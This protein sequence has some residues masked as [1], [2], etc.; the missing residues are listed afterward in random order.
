[1]TLVR[2]WKTRIDGIRQRY[3][4]KVEEDEDDDAKT[5]I[6]EWIFH[7]EYR[8]GS[9]SG[10]RHWEVR[11]QV[12]N[13]VT[14]GEAIGYAEDILGSYVDEELITASNFETDKAG[15]DFIKYG[16]SLDARYK[17]V[18]TVRPQYNYPKNRWGKWRMKRI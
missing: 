12:P 8:D 5:H 6:V 10:I 7:W 9:P 18:D 2:V 1:M 17:I 3:W 15:I 16:D 13:Y 4:V 14:E 11:L